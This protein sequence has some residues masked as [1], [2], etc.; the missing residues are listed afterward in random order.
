MCKMCY[1]YIYD[2]ITNP[3]PVNHRLQGFIR[4]PSLKRCSEELATCFHRA[5]GKFDN[6]PLFFVMLDDA[7]DRIEFEPDPT[8]REL[9]E[10]EW[11]WKRFYRYYP[12][13]ASELTYAIQV[14][15][16]NSIAKSTNRAEQIVINFFIDR[17]RIL[18]SVIPLMHKNHTDKVS[19]ERG[20]SLGSVPEEKIREI[21]TKA[22]L[23]CSFE[24]HMCISMDVI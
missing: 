21:R 3:L 20:G 22:G 10:D 15:I 19:P 9:M 14:A 13:G 1:A 11:V 4:L 24:D 8:I 17:L 2:T 23:A 7:D 12:D 6:N 16:D 18:L 5:I